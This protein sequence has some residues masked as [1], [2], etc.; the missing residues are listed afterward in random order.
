MDG[1]TAGSQ[2]NFPGALG[3]Q[4]TCTFASFVDAKSTRDLKFARLQ[5]SGELS[6]GAS[7]RMY[8]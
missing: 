1:M 6:C 5:L 7:V 8:N 2:K 4:D 3:V